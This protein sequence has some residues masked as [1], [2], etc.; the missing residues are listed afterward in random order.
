MP[1]ASGLFLEIFQ[2][3]SFQDRSLPAVNQPGYG[4]IS[5]VVEDI[6]ATFEK[7]VEAGGALLGEIADFGTDEA[8]F[9]FVYLRDPEGNIIELE[10]HS[11]RSSGGSN[12]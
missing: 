11:P 5:F 8:P 9:H 4:H 7:I 10:Q 6:G 12:P 3:K 2:Y 1:D